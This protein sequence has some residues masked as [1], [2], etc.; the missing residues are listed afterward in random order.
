MSFDKWWSDGGELTDDRFVAW[1]EQI[2][3]GKFGD[4]MHDTYMIRVVAE[5]AWQAGQQ[6]ERAACVVVAEDRKYSEPASEY[7]EGA[8]WACDSIVQAI[9]A[10]G[11]GDRSNV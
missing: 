6:A 2:R 1:Y 3:G 9:R 5:S 10:R 4:P 8:N 11:A 7:G